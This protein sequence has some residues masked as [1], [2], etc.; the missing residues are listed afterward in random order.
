MKIMYAVFY[1]RYPDGTYVLDVLYIEIK[2]RRCCN[3]ICRLSYIYLNF[4]VLTWFAVQLH[5]YCEKRR[6]V[7]AMKLY[8]MKHD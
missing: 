5:A 3:V 6:A 7:W 1:Y 8:N 2:Q 4:V